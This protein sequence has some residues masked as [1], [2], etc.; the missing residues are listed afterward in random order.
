[1]QHDAALAGNQIDVYVEELTESGTVTRTAIEVKD[2][3]R[4][5]VVDVVHRF[6][7]LIHLLRKRGL[8]D[9]A[10]IVSSAGFTRQ[11]CKVADEFDIVLL[12]LEDLDQ[13]IRGKQREFERAKREIDQEHLEAQAS[14]SR[15]KR[16]FVVMPFT[17]EFDD[18]YILGVREVAERMRLIVERADDVEHNENIL[19][20]IQEKIRTSDAV[21]AD[22]TGQNPNVFYEVGYSHAAQ[23]PTILISRKGSKI[24]FD[25]QSL[26][27]IFYE[28]IVQL[29]EKLAKRL[30][31]TL[32]P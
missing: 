4:P 19:D 20:L 21:V 26:N 1:M 28:S 3:R 9:K 25:L 14:P 31:A 16:V 27:H 24:P 30:K 22:T 7:G 6:A 32:S 5:V 17:S 15:S 13:R 23:T 11:A 2:W 8:I 12:E 18:I 10:V 29:R